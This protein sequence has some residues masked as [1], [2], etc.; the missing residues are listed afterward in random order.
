MVVHD[1]K[2]PLGSLINTLQFLE[3]DFDNHISARSSRM[4]NNGIIAGDQMMRLLHTL[5]AQQK[6][7]MGDLI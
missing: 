1:L 6:L 5:L 3:I 2:T 4:L 7:E